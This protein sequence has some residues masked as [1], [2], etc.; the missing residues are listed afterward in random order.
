MKK[1][2]TFIAIILVLISC[3]NTTLNSEGSIPLKQ[4]DTVILNPQ[5]K[6]WKGFRDDPSRGKIEVILS[7]Y[8]DS[9]KT[10]IVSVEEK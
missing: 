2:M 1:L 3:K 4:I 10:F 8:T 9:T 7:N 6:N 5:Q